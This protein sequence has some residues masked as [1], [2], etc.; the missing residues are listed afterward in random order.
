MVLMKYLGHI[1]KTKFYI[2]LCNILQKTVNNDINIR[3]Y[4]VYWI[5]STEESILG[6]SGANWARRDRN[7]II[8]FNFESA[9]NRNSFSS[10]DSSSNSIDSG[11]RESYL[12]N[13]YSS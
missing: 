13:L 10:S 9:S 7:H 6:S 8:Y 12:W 4:K 3:T 1:N 11:D 5:V 2:M